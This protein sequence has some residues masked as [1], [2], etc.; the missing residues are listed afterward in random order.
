MR[1]RDGDDSLSLPGT[2]FGDEAL[3]LEQEAWVELLRTGQ[4]PAPPA[5]SHR[6][7]TRRAAG[8]LP[9]LEAADGWLPTLHL[10][11]VLAHAGDS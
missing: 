11:V 1:E 4:M 10:G 3:G 2:P 6:P 5:S 7:P 8:G 9:L